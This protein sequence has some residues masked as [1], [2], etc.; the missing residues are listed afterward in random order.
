MKIPRPSQ[1]KARGQEVWGYVRASLRDLR[2][3]VSMLTG[4]QHLLA[5]GANHLFYPSPT[6]SNSSRREGRGIFGSITNL[7]GA[8]VVDSLQFFVACFLNS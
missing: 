7:S 4:A 3:H 1:A 2:N 8:R 6:L 5:V